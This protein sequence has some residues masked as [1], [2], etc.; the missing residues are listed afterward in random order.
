PTIDHGPLLPSNQ[1]DVASEVRRSCG[2]GQ[3]DSLQPLD[4]PLVPQ[5]AGVECRGWLEQE[6]MDFL[7]GHGPV[8]DATRY[9]QE[10]ALRQPDM[11]ISELHPK[12]PLD[13]EEHLVL[14]LVVVPHERPSELDQLDLLT[15][16]LT[17]DFGLLVVSEEAELLNEVDL[18]HAFLPYDLLLD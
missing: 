4:R 15:V 16:Q 10:F 14:I 18:L 3:S 5:V 8:F 12:P 11:A 17:D 6:D 2:G 13:D 1:P 9:D 7:L